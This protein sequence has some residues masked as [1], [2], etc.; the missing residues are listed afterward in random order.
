[1]APLH[2]YDLVLL[3]LDGLLVDSEQLHWKAYKYMCNARGFPFPWDFT[4]YFKI[5]EQGGTAIQD[6]LYAALPALFDKEPDWTILYQEKREALYKIAANEPVDLMPGVS[7]FLKV[8][9]KFKT[10]RAIVTHS[11]R[12]LVELL[13]KQQP[14]LYTIPTWICR[15]EYSRPKPDPEGYLV[16][17]SKFPAVKRVIGFEDAERGVAALKAAGIMAVLV[18]HSVPQKILEKYPGAVA[19]ARISDAL[20][21]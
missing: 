3:D 19:F 18:G 17:L 1:M 16:A 14:I 5:A 10:P 9:E 15:E 11:P 12:A 6:Q 8:L 21:W 20:S 7:D 4:T 13:A 2:S